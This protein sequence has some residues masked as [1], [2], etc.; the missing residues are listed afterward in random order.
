MEWLRNAGAGKKKSTA[1]KCATIPETAAS[2]AECPTPGNVPDI[3]GRTLV[4]SLAQKG[5]G[6]ALAESAKLKN[7][8]APAV[9]EVEATAPA[10]SPPPRERWN[11]QTS[12]ISSGNVCNEESRRHERFALHHETTPG[13]V[14]VPGTGLDEGESPRSNRSS[15]SS[16]GEVEGGDDESELSPFSARVVQEGD[17]SALRGNTL[18][19]TAGLESSGADLILNMALRDAPLVDGCVVPKREE[20]NRCKILH[21][22]HVALTI[23]VFVA[24][25]I[26][27]IVATVLVVTRKDHPSVGGLDD[28]PEE[29]PT[30]PPTSPRFQA[31]KRVVA[32]ISSWEDVSNPA[33]PQFQALMWLADVDT[34]RIP[35]DDISAVLQRYSV[36]VLYFSTGGDNWKNNTNYLTER[37]ECIWYGLYCNS[38]FHVKQI[39]LNINNLTGTIPKELFAHELGIIDLH[40]NRIGGTISDYVCNI[41]RTLTEMILHSNS[42]TGTILPCLGMLKNLEYLNLR[43]NLLKGP[44]PESLNKLALVKLDLASNDL[45]GQITVDFDRMSGSLE[46]LNLFDNMLSGS[47]PPSVKLFNGTNLL[48]GDNIGMSGI[49]PDGIAKG[50]ASRLEVLG[51]WNMGLT[52]TIPKSV[53]QMKNLVAL[54]LSKNELSGHLP[55]EIGRT[56]LINIRGITLERNNL[57][58]TIPSSVGNL[59]SLEALS[60]HSNK[61]TGTIPRSIGKLTAMK[62]L[63]FGNNKLVGEMPHSARNLTN[64]AFLSVKKNDLEGDLNFLCDLSKLMIL[65]ADC[66]GNDAEVDCKCCGLFCENDADENSNYFD[67]V[68]LIKTCYTSED[69]YGNVDIGSVCGSII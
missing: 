18:R 36:V 26:A 48:L 20:C 19:S 35:V 12:R 45:T 44:I 60:M 2:V 1:L 23:L 41:S 22:R 37:H 29:A 62:W 7:V 14:A 31:M 30:P 53:F 4:E 56:P 42:L 46:L 24:S 68:M 5:G 61:L 50:E 63:D 27:G 54:A 10:P 67:L 3:T 66:K 17:N 21:Q 51:L 33:S 39:R 55:Q 11:G 25:A 49:I 40:S 32:D 43:E 64:L 6:E 34:K 65:F 38:S 13:A 15:H 57:S 8:P 69:A 58:G 16:E 28:A 52:G 9:S 47:I 59:S